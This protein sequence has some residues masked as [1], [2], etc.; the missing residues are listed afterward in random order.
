M[1][2]CSL[3]VNDDTKNLRSNPTAKKGDKYIQS[4]QKE[5][6]NKSLGAFAV[7]INNK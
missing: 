1:L 3:M 2:S 6:A 4:K 5:I 7:L